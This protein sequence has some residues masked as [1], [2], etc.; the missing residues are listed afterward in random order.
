MIINVHLLQPVCSQLLISTPL[1][2]SNVNTKLILQTGA[3][4]ELTDPRGIC[5]QIVRQ[6]C[7]VHRNYWGILF[8]IH[9]LTSRVIKK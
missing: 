6:E 3:L 4:H 2:C 7:M 8:F 1:I 5:W 9:P